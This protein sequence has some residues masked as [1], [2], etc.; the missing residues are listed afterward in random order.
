MRRRFLSCAMAAAALAA[1]PSISLAQAAWPARPVRF[2]VAFAPAG[3]A[4]IIGRLVAQRL[5]GALGQSV[6]V[7]NRAGA[8]GSVASAVVARAEPDGYTLLVNTSS[9]AV[10]PS[11][12]RNLGFDATKDLTLAALV[13]SSPNLIVIA[14]SVKAGTLKGVMADAQGG[15]YNYATA[16]AGTT[17]HLTA[18]YLFKVLGKVPVTHVPFQGA[19]PALNAVMGSQTQMASVALP[20]A[21]ELVKSGRVRGLVVTGSKRS[22]ALPAV[23]TV[24]ESGFPGFE[25]VTWVGIFAPS[26][27]PRAVLERVNAEVARLQQDPDFLAKL[28]AAG[29]DPLGGSVEQSKAYLQ[30]ELEKWAQVVKETGARPN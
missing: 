8:G 1:A 3:P 5:T 4:D 24:A 20:A 27:T 23:P 14:P 2:V 15:A 25:D 9:Y 21:V 6:I 10:N 17:P 16:G 29:F 12:Q 30:K 22:S 13:A 18:E 7:E 26:H 19:G 11:M 28:S